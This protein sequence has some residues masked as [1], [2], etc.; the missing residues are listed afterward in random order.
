M[1]TRPFVILG[2]TLLVLL[3]LTAFGIRQYDWN[4]SALLHMDVP[5][6]E[7]HKVPAGVVLYTDAAYDGMLYYQVARDIPA[8]ITGGETS[9]TSPYRFQR[10]LLPLFGYILTLGN[11]D[12]F[13]IAFLLINI[14]SALLVLFLMLKMT[15][16]KVLHALTVVFNPAILIGIL[17]M[18]TEP[19]SLLFIVAFLYIWKNKNYTVTPLGI[20]ILM[21]SLLA[22]ETTVFLIGLLILWDVWKKEWKQVL[23]LIIPIV[24]LALWQYV[25]ELRF[26]AVGFQANSNIIDFPF[27]GPIQVFVWLA[28]RIK[29]TYLLSS[30]GLMLFVF[31]LFARMCGEWIRKRTRID[32]LAFVLSGLTFTMITMDAHMWGAITSIGRVVTPIY[33]VYPLYA[34]SRDTWV[35]KALSLILII[36]SIIAAIGIAWAKHPYVIS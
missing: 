31:P 34:A 14:I 27:G 19:L 17:Y 7:T 9:Y 16:G 3:G 26:G 12:Y 8:L 29:V 2:S 6:G 23:L 24:L 11:E 5:F 25:L 1:F 4:M 20:A 13:S 32:I 10:I 28:Q 15:G 22:R 18:L 33:A 21:L 35:E 30:I 36:V